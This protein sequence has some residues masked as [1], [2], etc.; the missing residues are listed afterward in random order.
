[1]REE[2][3]PN[4]EAELIVTH[5][6]MGSSAVFGRYAFLGILAAIL[7]LAVPGRASAQARKIE[8]G[9][10]QKIVGVTNPEISPDGKSIVI[11][12]SRVNWDEDRYD[13]QLV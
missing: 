5:S 1:M 11:V 12:V 8:L 3:L 9:E 6:K 7:A 2:K 13:S 4:W 10:F